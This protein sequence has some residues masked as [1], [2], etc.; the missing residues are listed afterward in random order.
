M[1]AEA[2]SVYRP[3]FLLC[4]VALAQWASGAYAH[5]SIS[6]VYDSARQVTVEGVV[7]EFRFVN[8]H[9]VLVIDVAGEGAVHERWQLE[10]DNRFE[11]R[12]IGMT[13]DTFKAGDRVVA[14]GSAAR[15]EGQRLYLLRLDRPADGLHYE[16]VGTRPSIEVRGRR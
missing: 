11:L 9:P 2:A 7:T 8:P 13:A 5:H 12:G 6:G 1:S 10:M 14:R 4:A 3:T 16:Q 15:R